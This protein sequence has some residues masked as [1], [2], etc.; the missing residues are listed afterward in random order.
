[1]RGGCDTREH[2][3]YQCELTKWVW[4]KEIGIREEKFQAHSLEGWL[5]E[6]K[7]HNWE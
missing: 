4:F 6:K 1:M 3:I 2:M 7:N 5:K